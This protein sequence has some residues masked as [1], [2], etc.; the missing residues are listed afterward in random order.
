MTTL[1]GSGEKVY[2]DGFGTFASFMY[3]E[4]VAV[5]ISGYLYLLDVFSQRVR[6]IS[7]LGGFEALCVAHVSNYSVCRF[8]DDSGG[9]W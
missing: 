5:D 8:G 7:P 2:A 4:G 1:A 3:P 6:K 9:L